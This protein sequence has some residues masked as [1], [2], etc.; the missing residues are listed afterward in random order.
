MILLTAHAANAYNS[1]QQ[2]WKQVL[3]DALNVCITFWVD[4]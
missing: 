1:L 2:T 3:A 4:T